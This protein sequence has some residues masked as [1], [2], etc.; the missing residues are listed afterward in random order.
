[1][2]I[3]CESHTL[4]RILGMDIPRLHNVI[5]YGM[6]TTIDD[7][8]QETGRVGRDGQQSHAIILH[9]RDSTKGKHMTSEVK[10]YTNLQ[11]CRRAA[12]LKWFDEGSSSLTGTLYCC[13]NCS[14]KYSCC[15]CSMNEP[16][17]HNTQSCFCVKWCFMLSI[18][19]R[20]IGGHAPRIACRETMD[21]TGKE[22]C[23]EAML[24][25]RTVQSPMLPNY[26]TSLVYPTLVDN[27]IGAHPYIR[28]AED[29]AKLGAY[30]LETA[31]A[32]LDI[33]NTFSVL[34][35][36][37]VVEPA[38]LT[39]EFGTSSGSDASESEELESDDESND[40]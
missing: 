19:E 27:I 26:V 34:L 17:N 20:Q 31:T 8:M 29:I 22:K 16:C 39:D 24:T 37:A 40:M 25:Q 5:H 38:T 6:P 18:P 23:R 13:D 30:N 4:M 15:S 7:Y 12:I 11:S 32:L 9:H 35:P 3:L 21:P 2:I 1:M 28:N 10:E 36:T 14:S 33:L